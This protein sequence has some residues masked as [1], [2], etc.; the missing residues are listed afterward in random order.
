MRNILETIYL[1]KEGLAKLEAELREFENVKMKEASDALEDARK[2]GDLSEN[3][4]YDAARDN[5]HAVSL[6]I[7]TLKEK[8]ARVQII[9]S[10]KIGNDCIRILNKVLLRDLD[11]KTEFEYILVSPEEM[12]LN[13]GKISVNSPVGKALI[14]KKVGET[15]KFTV[16][17][18]PKKWKVLRID[19][20]QV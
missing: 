18:G 11:K 4:E 3:A 12:D 15:V 5:I 14:G 6:H 9:D 1:T 8:L 13:I 2:H 20:P 16:P 17:A 7:M 10:S 19:P